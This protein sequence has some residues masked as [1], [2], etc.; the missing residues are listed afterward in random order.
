MQQIG[1]EQ[2]TMLKTVVKV[3]LTCNKWWRWKLPCTTHNFAEQ[4]GIPCG[5]RT[6]LIHISTNS[7]V[8]LLMLL[9]KSILLGGNC[10]THGCFASGYTC[11]HC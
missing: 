8:V 5:T 7:F 3:I 4:Y 6:G 10:S 1:A 2:S 11:S 9:C